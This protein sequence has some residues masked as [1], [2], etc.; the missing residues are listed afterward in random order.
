VRNKCPEHNTETLS[1]GCHVDT[2]Q[3]IDYHEAIKAKDKWIKELLD[4]VEELKELNGSDEIL[5]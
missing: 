1:C 2:L 3:D 4:E 5:L